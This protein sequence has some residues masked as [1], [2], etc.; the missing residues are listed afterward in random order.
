MMQ[1]FT[2]YVTQLGDSVEQNYQ[3][4]KSDMEYYHPPVVT[5]AVASC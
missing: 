5:Y 3:G 1:F 4:S 2:I